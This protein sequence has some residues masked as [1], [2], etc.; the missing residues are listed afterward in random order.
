MK[1]P[2]EPSFKSTNAIEKK[3]EEAP[4]KAEKTNGHKVAVIGSG[5]A[6]LTCAGDL[7][8]MGYDVTIFEALHEAVNDQ[9]Q[10]SSFHGYMPECGA[11]FLRSAVAG[12]YKKRGV[13][14]S[15][16]EVFVSSGASDE[17]G[18]ILDLFVEILIK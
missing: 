5:P 14:L 2:K 9:S 10:K 18:D 11:P 15:D 7:A 13:Q 8:K 6:G 16:D 12:Y 3:K 4:K 1:F 17:L